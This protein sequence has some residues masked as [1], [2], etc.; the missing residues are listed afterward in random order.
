MDSE[1]PITTLPA[2]STLIAD[3][4][5]FVRMREFNLSIVRRAYELYQASGF[6][7]VHDL[8]V[9]DRAVSEMLMEVPVTV[10]ESDGEISVCAEVPGFTAHEIEIKVDSCRIFITGKQ[11]LTASGNNEAASSEQTPK[12]F[13]REC[14]LPAGIESGNVT[15]ELKDGVL[16][17]RL[18]KCAGHTRLLVTSVAA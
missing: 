9:W 12:E 4:L 3:D 5:F 13:I 15:A 2:I 1:T 16:E 14:L 11:E 18:P 6:R 10:A 7:D 8:E 17:I